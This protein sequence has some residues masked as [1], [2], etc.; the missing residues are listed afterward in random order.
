MIGRFGKR[1]TMKTR[2]LSL[3]ALIFFLLTS[4]CQPEPEERAEQLAREQ[5]IGVIGA[6]AVKRSVIEVHPSKVGWIVIFREAN[7][8]CEE[9][10]FW[11]GACRFENR[12][13]RDAYACVERN[14][15]IR[16]MGTGGESESLGNEDLCQVPGPVLPTAK[17]NP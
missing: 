4:A 8:S 15:S 17:P 11:P 6:N 5:M 2:F 16:Q 7:A 10:S 9:G 13:F 12:L 14:W 1:T 3:I